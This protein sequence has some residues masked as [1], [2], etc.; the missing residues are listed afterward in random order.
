MRFFIID[1]NN[2]T[3]TKEAFEGDTV[4]DYVDNCA[5]YDIDTEITQNMVVEEAEAIPE[6]TEEQAN[7]T[8]VDVFANGSSQGLRQVPIGATAEEVKD[9]LSLQGSVRIRL[10]GAFCDSVPAEGT[11]VVLSSATKYEGA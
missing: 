2:T 10:H 11:A 9:L 1:L 6:P 4:G 3:I 8:N 5:N 7:L